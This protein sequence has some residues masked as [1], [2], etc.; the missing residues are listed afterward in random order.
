MIKV[1]GSDTKELKPITNS[2]FEQI[3]TM[4]DPSRD[5][6]IKN[7]LVDVRAPSRLKYSFISITNDSDNEDEFIVVHIRYNIQYEVEIR[8]QYKEDDF[9]LC[10][11]EEIGNVFKR[12]KINR[13]VEI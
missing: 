1:K 8:Y 10:S 2:V 4:L 9:S 13:H 5:F 11:L 7:L 3:K 6:G 12:L